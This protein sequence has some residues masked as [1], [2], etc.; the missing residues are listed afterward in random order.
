MTV[1]PKFMR[2]SF[3]TRGSDPTQVVKWTLKVGAFKLEL[4]EFFGDVSSTWTWRGQQV[5]FTSPLI[6]P[7]FNALLTRKYIQLEA[8]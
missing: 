1:M 2:K 8:Q 7:R 3:T 6:R 4:T 5:L